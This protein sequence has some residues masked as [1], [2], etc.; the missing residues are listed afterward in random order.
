M[1]YFEGFAPKITHLNTIDRVLSS[2]KHVRITTM[3][4]AFFVML[5]KAGWIQRLLT[6]W[7]FAWRAASRFV[8]GETRE[9]ALN[10][11]RQLNRS[12]ILVTLDHLGESTST[13]E[14]ARAASVEIITLL[15]EIDRA[16]LHSNVSIKLSQIGLKIDPDLC[17]EELI[18]ILDRARALGNFIRIDMEDSSLTALTLDLY[19]RAVQRG[20]SNVGVV[21]Q[22]YLYRTDAD[23]EHVLL[24]GGRVR[25]C[26][27][28]YNEPAAVAYPRKADVDENYDRLTARLLQGALNCSAPELSPD[29]RTPPIPAFATHDPDRIA[30]VRRT[31]T[32]VNFPQ[33][34]LEFQMLFGI[35]RDLQESL[36]A[37]GYPVRVYVPYGDH[38]Y[39][40][41][42]RRLGERP[43]NMWFFLS[44]FIRN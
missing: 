29:G 6:R 44:N 9:D 24:H 16:G 34:A 26:K 19:E 23:L 10:V 28:A 2:Y 21:L 22:S 33:R 7:G 12:G 20:Y 41:L 32:E 42:M 31:A 1:G 36:A 3:L 27:G 4:R 18:N 13:A 25:L 15:E 39:P 5:S 40:Y 14:A 30:Y 17:F 43:A 11:V 38:W 8:A 37:S 35:R